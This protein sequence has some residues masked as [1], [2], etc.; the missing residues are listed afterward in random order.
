MAFFP[1]PLLS[2]GGLPVV[3]KET[4]RVPDV[5]VPFCGIRPHVIKPL[6]RFALRPV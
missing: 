6:G 4:P 5:C 3:A 1:P 2:H